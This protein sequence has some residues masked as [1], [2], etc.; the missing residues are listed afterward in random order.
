MFKN[1]LFLFSVLF[2]VILTIFFRVYNFNNRYTF[3]WDQTDDAVK[4]YSMITE[5]KPILIGPRVSNDSG[6]F[7]GPYHYYFLL[8][9]YL[10]LNGNPIAGFWAAVTVSV[11][12]TLIIYLFGQKIFGPEI[13]FFAASF[14]AITPSIISWNVMY[15]SLLSIII[16]YL[17]WQLIKGNNKIFPLL[18][19]IYGFSSNTHLVPISLGLPIV[20][21]FIISPKKPSLKNI[22]FSLFLFLIPF[23]PLLIFDLRHQFFNSHQLLNFVFKPKASTDLPWYLFLRSYWRYFNFFTFKSTF[24]TIIFRIFI[25]GLILYKSISLR[26]KFKNLILVWSL[27]PL[28][29]LAFY[30]GNIPEYYY[31]AAL[32]ILPFLLGSFLYD[33]KKKWPLILFLIVLFYFQFL[34]INRQPTGI[35][36]KNKVGVVEYLVNQKEDQ[37]F[38]V[39]YD[40]PLGMN[41]GYDYLFT[42]YKNKPQDIPAAHLYTIYL[43]SSLPPSGQVVYTNSVI[44]LVRR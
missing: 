16:F 9:F 18:L 40:L 37:L 38:N 22:F 34:S 12:T 39:S 2:L 1:K 10:V 24:L 41:T 23:L 29:L 8:P 4:V 20:Y 14:Y 33:F 31:G 5:K 32:S 19:L 35:L 7:I 15:T 25:I 36:L 30:H 26:S 28:I 21:S 43:T 3:E 6:F 42:Y 11:A 17:C 27:A 13:A 44:G